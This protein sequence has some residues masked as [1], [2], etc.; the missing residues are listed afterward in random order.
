MNAN[1]TAALAE[2]ERFMRRCIELAKIAQKRNNTPV[3]S[4]VVVDGEVVGE[5]VEDLPAGILVTG[6]AE[7]LACQ[8]AVDK[9]GSP[10]LDG[11]SL[12]TTAEPCFMCSYVI[13]QSG[14]SLVVYGLDTPHV[15]GVTSSHPILTDTS[16]PDWKPAPSVLAGILR[17]E[18]QQLKSTSPEGSSD[19]PTSGA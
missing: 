18:C 19:R 15:G 13:R 16:I 5:G 11:A 2:H 10:R 8:A 14:I 7:I 3:G 9:T 4:V 1:D 12:Y 6:H 17:D